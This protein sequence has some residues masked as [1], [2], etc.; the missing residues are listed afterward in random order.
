[1]TLIQ[2]L[3]GIL[4][5][6]TNDIIDR[7]DKNLIGLILYGSFSYQ[8]LKRRTADFSELFGE[9]GV[10]DK[11]PDYVA[12]VE[13]K[14][15]ALLT[16]TGM[17]CASGIDDLLLKESKG[18]SKSSPNYVTIS[19]ERAYDIQLSDSVQASQITSKVGVVSREQFEA[20]PDYDKSAVYLAMRLSKPVN[21]MYAREDYGR[22]MDVRL[23]KSRYFI[24]SEARSFLPQIFSG[25][26]ILL[27]YANTYRNEVYR[28]FD[29][30][31]G[32]HK[33][34][35]NGN[36]YDVS[37]GELVTMRK[38]ISEIV[39][40]CLGYSR[41]VIEGNSEN[42]FEESGFFNVQDKSDNRFD[43]FKRII[44][45]NYY[46]LLA[47]LKNSRSNKLGCE[48]NGKYLLRKFGIRV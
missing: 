18:K 11:K 4:Y 16:L 10:L 22:S 37:K 34:V 45:Q 20:D 32:K 12:I 36:F 44:V 26:D 19:T 23:F 9:K 14:R 6:S 27:S 7:L 30:V 38:A 48:S 21:V 24:F 1:M 43:I 47:S 25:E 17:E 41:D 35:L 28:I 46:S 42:S 3:D 39:L 5:S 15:N 31:K 40:D 13:D 8:D 29:I 33:S 2:R